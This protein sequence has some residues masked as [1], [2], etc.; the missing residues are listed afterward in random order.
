MPAPAASEAAISRALSAASAA[1]L[2]VS[3]FSVSRDGTVTVETTPKSVD[4]P[5]P[6]VQPITPKAWGKRG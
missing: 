1:G 4:S 6:N 2:Q 3:S 5:A